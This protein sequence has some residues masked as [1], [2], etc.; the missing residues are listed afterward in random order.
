MQV[1]AAA[2]SENTRVPS[3]QNRRRTMYLLIPILRLQLTPYGIAH[4]VYNPNRRG[5][6][7]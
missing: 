5:Y 7:E 2:T 1:Q 6:A 4:L 3:Y